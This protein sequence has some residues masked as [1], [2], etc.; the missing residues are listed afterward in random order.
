MDFYP[1][2]DS[3]GRWARIGGIKKSELNNLEVD[4]LNRCQFDLRVSS[5]EFSDMVFELIRSKKGRLDR[6]LFLKT[7]VTQARAARAAQSRHS[8]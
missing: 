8:T 5:Q 7:K 6:I 2:L 3:N 1:A 4:F